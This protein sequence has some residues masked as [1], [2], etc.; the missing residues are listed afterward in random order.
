M[1]ED[2]PPAAGGAT[3]AERPRPHEN[4]YWVPGTHVLA[5][6]YPVRRWDDVGRPRIA[7]LLDAGIR[8]FIDLT[9][10]GEG[11]LPSYV[12]MVAEEAELRGITA[13]YSRMSFRDRSVPA[14][15]AEMRAILDTL[16]AAEEAGEA[17]YLHCWG[18]V[19]RTGTVVGCLLVNRGVTG[20]EALAAVAALFATTS[21]EKQMNH[22]E[23]SPQTVEQ[24]EFVAGWLSGGE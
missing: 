8:R 15:V 10:E 5:G 20:D 22:P 4:C 17:T 14:T 16:E 13:S 6:E 18:G 2:Q 11:G 24:C 9:E 23:G 12:H 1:T 21:A 7:A 19:G 3:P